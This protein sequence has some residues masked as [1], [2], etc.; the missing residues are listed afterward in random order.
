MTYEEILKA[1]KEGK[2]VHWSNDGYKV[3]IDKNGKV[4]ISFQDKNF[5]GLSKEIFEKDYKAK[6]FYIG[7][8][9]L[10]ESFSF[11]E[12]C[13]YLKE[14]HNEEFSEEVEN[15]LKELKLAYN[16]SQG[17]Y[18]TSFIGPKFIKHLIIKPGSYK[19]EV[20]ITLYSGN[21]KDEHID[22][23][24]EEYELPSKEQFKKFLDSIEKFAEAEAEMK[25]QWN[26]R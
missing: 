5:V 19:D 23:E 24:D 2:D 4:L 22:F 1:V 6:D 21:I 13:S 8:K 20:H 9:N 12:Y 11:S 26:A 3:I 10:K 18:H 17:W 16:S 15:K 7:K 14:S 25:K